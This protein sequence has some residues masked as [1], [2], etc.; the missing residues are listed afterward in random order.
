MVE[1]KKIMSADEI[2]K[3]LARIA[4]EITERNIG[5]KR[6]AIIGV[7]RRGVFLAER[8][9]ELISSQMDTEL[10]IGSIDITFYGTDH[11]VIDKF[12][13]LNGTNIPFSIQDIPVVLV[14]DILYTGKTIHR[15]INALLGLGEPSEIQLAAFLD[16][17]R[18]CFPISADYVGARMPSAKLERIA[19]HLSEIDADDE[20]IIEKKGFEKI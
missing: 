7:V 15:A 6:L 4:T 13:Q 10:L 17:G 19:L 12:P 8:L 11:Q 2:E 14:D 9:A 20:V 16:R 3:K 1:T 18:R 5:A